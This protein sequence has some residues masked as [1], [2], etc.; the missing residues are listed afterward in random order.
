MRNFIA[1]LEILLL[2]VLKV[3]PSPYYDYYDYGKPVKADYDYDGEESPVESKCRRLKSDMSFVTSLCYNRYVPC[4]TVN[5]ILWGVSFLKNMDI[6]KDE[7]NEQLIDI[8][9]NIGIRYR[10]P[11]GKTQMPIKDLIEQGA[12]GLQSWME[13]EKK[14]RAIR[15]SEGSEPWAPG[16]ETWEDRLKSFEEFNKTWVEKN[17]ESDA[18]NDYTDMLDRIMASREYQGEIDGLDQLTGFY[19]LIENLFSNSKKRSIDVTQIK[20][21]KDQIKSYLQN[22]AYRQSLWNYRVNPIEI[23]IQSPQA[24]HQPN[25]ELALRMAMVRYISSQKNVAET[26]FSLFECAGL[27]K[28]DP[29]IGISQNDF[30]KYMEA[31]EKEYGEAGNQNLTGPTDNNNI[32]TKVENKEAWLSFYDTLIKLFSS[33]TKQIEGID[34][35]ELYFE[36]FNKYHNL[37]IFLKTLNHDRMFAVWIDQLYVMSRMIAIEFESNDS[38]FST[39]QNSL[40]VAKDKE[41]L[42]ILNKGYQHISNLYLNGG[43]VPNEI[44]EAISKGIKDFAKENGLKPNLSDMFRFNTEHEFKITAILKGYI[45]KHDTSSS[46]SSSECSDMQDIENSMKGVRRVVSDLSPYKKH[47]VYGEYKIERYVKHLNEAPEKMKNLCEQVAKYPNTE[48]SS[49]DQYFKNILNIIDLKSIIKRSAKTILTFTKEIDS[50]LKDV[51]QYVKA[52]VSVAKKDED[53]ITEKEEFMLDILEKI[54]KRIE[55][56]Q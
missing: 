27:L 16:M 43:F 7:I 1:K 33:L 47:S 28:F 5:Q 11:D 29:L 48:K 51:I 42:D 12:S 30:M 15:V 32:Q 4:Q 31:V 56:T 14:W 18:L 50:I 20:D 19:Y 41:F 37:K 49:L 54:G 9:R 17:D 36:L 26:F 22:S 38:L 2:F 55:E 53:Y 23:F 35:D 10:L 8:L 46:T 21:L 6:T 44:A 25:I 13:E 39:L 52:H 40:S 3:C 45:E 24:I 34:Y